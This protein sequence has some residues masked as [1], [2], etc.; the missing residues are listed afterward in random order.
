MVAQVRRRCTA[1]PVGRAD[2]VRY[3]PCVDTFTPAMLEDAAGR[4]AD[5]K[6]TGKLAAA[7][8]AG[9]GITLTA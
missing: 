5:R 9:S 6:L 1:S 2:A 3:P 8:V 4:F 7:L